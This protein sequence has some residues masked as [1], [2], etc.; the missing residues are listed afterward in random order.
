M[1]VGNDELTDQRIVF[2]FFSLFSRFEYALKRGGFLRHGKTAKPNWE[3]YSKTLLGSFSKVNDEGFKKA[4]DYLKDLP[5]RRQVVVQHR[6]DWEDTIQESG[7]F[8]ERYLL[9]L[10]RIVRNNLFHGGKYPYSFGPT[11]TADRNR[12]LLEASVV[13]L[14]QCLSLSPDLERIFREDESDAEET[15]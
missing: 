13:I 7:E 8:M 9:R 2:H 3:A 4:C 12:R 14:K 11:R 1:V 10:V 15:A 6:M 5:P